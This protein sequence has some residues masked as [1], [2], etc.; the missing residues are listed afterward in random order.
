MNDSTSESPLAAGDQRTTVLYWVVAAL[1]FIAFAFQLVFHAVRTSVIIDEPAHIMAGYRHWQ[2]ADFGINPEHPPLLKLTAAAPLMFKTWEHAP[3]ECGA[4]MTAKTQM[5]STGNNFLVDNG[6]DNVVIPA[7]L[8]AALMSLLLA[9]AVFFAAREMFGA[10][11]ALIALAILAFESNLIAHGSMVT[12][13]MTLSAT[14]FI[15]VY[16]LYRYCKQQSWQR[17]FVCGVAVGLMLAAK[18]SAVVFIPVLFCLLIA[19]AVIYR[20]IGLSRPV[21]LWRTIGTFAGLFLVGLVLL[22]AFYGF[23]HA[24]IPSTTA[25]TISVSDYIKEN[26][27]PEMVRSL[28]ARVT[29][30]IGQ[31]RTFPESYVLGMADVIAWGSRNTW[32]FGENYA[33]GRWWYFPLAFSVKSSLALLILLPIG[34]VFAV[35]ARDKRREMMFILIPAFVFFA[36]AMTSSFTT[37]V[38]HILPT[39][40]FFIITAAVGAVWLAPRFPVLKAALPLILVFHAAATLRAAPYYLAFSN[41]LWGGYENTHRVFRDSNVDYGQSLKAVNEYL[42]RENITDCW[43]A[44]FNHRELVNAIQ[45]CRVLP[46]ALR[47]IVPQNVIDPV[48]QVIDGTVLV[49]VN[50]LPPRG[51]DDYVPFTRTEPVALIGGNTFVYRGRF[52]IPVAAAMSH[53]YRSGQFLRQNRVDEAIAEGSLAAGLAP[54]DPRT[55]LALGLALSRAGRKDEARNELGLTIELSRSRAVFRN[56]EVRALL[57]VDRLK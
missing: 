52:E 7:R 35:S 54:D 38:R 42:E 29:E 1:L 13:D 5:F 19:D 43:F 27:R 46:S 45:P 2:C 21:K 11:E 56:P 47:I 18:H 48:P 41:A 55:H 10:W 50:E 33:T 28:P 16:T 20:G 4:Q 39:Y 12:T 25:E 34:L 3:V 6:I 17:F 23:R 40:A 37:G 30:L 8:A 53:A 32:I 15:A 9:V 51:A 26:G 57:E 24:A 14:A 22:W 31:T 36:V 49:S 44:A